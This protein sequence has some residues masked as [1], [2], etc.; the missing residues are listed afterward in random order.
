[1]ADTVAV[2]DLRGT[3]AHFRRPDTLATH[4][5]YPFMPRTALRGL[6]AAV[7]GL[8]ELPAEARAG[9]RLLN[10]VRTIAQELSMH[11]KTWEA[12]SGKP[13]SFL[14]P[15]SVELVVNPSYRVYYAGPL[16]G[17]LAETLAA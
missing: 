9:L 7:L 17:E 6:V 14:R 4:A 2:F 16:T 1:M 8:G 13:D 11:G 10:P 3:L 5:S 12:G 15:T